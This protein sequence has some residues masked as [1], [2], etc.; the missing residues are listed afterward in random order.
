MEGLPNQTEL[1]ESSSSGA[2]GR[3]LPG[4]LVTV[5]HGFDKTGA[6]NLFGCPRRTV[7]VDW[8]R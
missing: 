5:A 6:A 3:Q 4:F 7:V 1:A 2:V 8:W